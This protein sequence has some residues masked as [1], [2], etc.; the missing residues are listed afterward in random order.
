ML[1][2]DQM[3]ER[4][5]KIIDAEGNRFDEPKSVQLVIAI[6]DTSAIPLQN[7]NHWLRVPDVICVFVDMKNST[8][9]SAYHQDKTTAGI[10]Q[11][12][13]Q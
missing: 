11:T 9:L 4:Y 6:P 12:G 13:S 10:Y 8:K 2:S 5:R 7:P 1:T 3:P